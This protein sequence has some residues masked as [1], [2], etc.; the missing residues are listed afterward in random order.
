MSNV[1]TLD[2]LREETKRKFAPVVIGLS[3]GSEVK[4]SSIL[5]LPKASRELVSTTIEQLDDLQPEEDD[6]ASIE[7]LS[8]A[9]SKVFNVIADKPAKLLKELDDEDPMVK[10]HMMGEVIDRWIGATQLGE[11]SNSPA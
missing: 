5:K 10:L 6:P 3:D 9:L 2:A 11:A 8:E 1:F 7:L 4:L